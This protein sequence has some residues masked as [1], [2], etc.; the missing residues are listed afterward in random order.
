MRQ[1]E[2]M[3]A[4]RTGILRAFI[5]AL[6]IS[7]VA[8]GTIIHPERQNQRAS[9]NLDVGIVIL[10]G[11][12]LFF[13]IIPGVIAYAVDFS[14]HTIYLPSGQRSGLDGPT[15]AK[16]HIDGK[17]DQAAIERA[18]RAETGAAVDMSRPDVQVIRLESPAEMKARLAEYQAGT[19]VA[20]A[21]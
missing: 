21:P 8:C 7:L 13:F 1:N 5:L 18:I 4:F 14:N 16:I 2:A 3:R 19:R 15:F 12:G 6:A 17:M 10:D 11:I 9:T 20:L